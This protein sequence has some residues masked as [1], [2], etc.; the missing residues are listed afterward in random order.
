MP[1]DISVQQMTDPVTIR[2]KIHETIGP[3]HINPRAAKELLGSLAEG[4]ALDRLGDVVG[5][6]R[7]PSVSDADYRTVIAQHM[8]MPKSEI[9]HM[10]YEPY[11]SRWQQIIEEIEDA[12]HGSD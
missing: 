6:Q 3:G 9:F 11:K 12:N 8:K 4:K 10:K 7:C 2:W 1:P 5:V